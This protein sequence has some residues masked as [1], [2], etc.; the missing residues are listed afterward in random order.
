VIQLSKKEKKLKLG[1]DKKQK[2]A[3]IGFEEI[4]RK[5]ITY[6]KPIV[7]HNGIFDILYIYQQFID[8]LP[9]DIYHFQ[10]QVN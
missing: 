1:S 2:E 6:E 10:N 3:T 9:D 4:V 8:V 7:F 5:L